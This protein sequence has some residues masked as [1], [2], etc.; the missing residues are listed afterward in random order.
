MSERPNVTV[1]YQEPK[2]DPNPGIDLFAW[3]KVAGALLALFALL[4]AC[5]WLI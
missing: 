4:R 1:I 2:P 3:L 5:A